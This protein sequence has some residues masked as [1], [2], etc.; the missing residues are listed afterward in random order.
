MRV[1]TG[2]RRGAT[3]DPSGRY[4]Y[5]L[6]RRWDPARPTIAFIMLNP[7][8]ADG[9]VDDPT[10]RRCIG[11]ARDWGFGALGVANLFGLRAREPAML[12]RAGDPVGPD[13]DRH[14]ARVA[15]RAQLVIAAWGNDGALLDRD[16]AVLAMLAA[17]AIPVHCLGTTGRGCPRHP[18]YLRREARHA[19]L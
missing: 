11:F 7:N 9:R 17:R 5:A 1:D 4:R 6:W 2:I 8:R 18:L 12:R 19:P 14:V 10:I 15:R 13:N 3:F 16:R